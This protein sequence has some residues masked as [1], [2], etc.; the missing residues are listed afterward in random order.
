MKKISNKIY[1]IKKRKKEIKICDQETY[2]DKK[3]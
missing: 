2:C 3:D 1:F